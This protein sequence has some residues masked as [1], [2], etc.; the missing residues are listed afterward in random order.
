MRCPKCHYISFDNGER[1]RNCGYEFSL[2]PDL[3]ALDL[4]IQTGNEPLGP[5]EDLALGDLDRGAAPAAPAGRR[6]PDP[7]APLRAPAQAARN[8]D[9]PLFKERV[10]HADAPLVTPPAAPRPPLAVRRASPVIPRAPAPPP[11]EEPRLDLAPPDPAEIPRADPGAAGDEAEVVTAPLVRRGFAAAIDGLILGTIDLAVL[12]FTLR[13][14]GLEP[15]EATLIPPVPFFAFLLLLNGG[16]VVSFTAANGQTIGK[17]AAAIKVVPAGE[18]GGWPDRVALGQ[19]VVRFA[20][21][22][23]SVLPA[24]L[25]MLP[26]VFSADGRAVH[27]RLAATRVIRA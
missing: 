18:S 7:A 2:S 3:N 23:V 17:M 11:V 12:Y 5:L 15:A 26:A 13:L 20:A 9:L 25:G 8:T 14:C 24:G 21:Y 27:D 4:P 1:C 19:A 16:Y 22:F 6:S 10:V